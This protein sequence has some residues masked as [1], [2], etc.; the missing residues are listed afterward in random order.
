MKS[1]F[2]KIKI[3]LKFKSKNL[4][5]FTLIEILVAT[6]L[7]VVIAVGGLSILFTAERNYKR[8]ASNSVAMD[9]INLVMDTLSREIK[10]G[11]RYGCINP[12]GSNFKTKTFYNGFSEGNL[13]DNVNNCNAIAFTPQGTTTEKIVYYYDL[14]NLGIN[15]VLYTKPSISDTSFNIVSNSDVALT[16]PDFKV[17]QFWFTIFGAKNNDYNQPNVGIYIDGIVDTVKNTQ[18]VIVATTSIF[19]QSTI[20]Q[21]I[22]DN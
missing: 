17:D 5:A 6:T 4:E 15:Q 18:G 22:L 9:N 20:S 21:R 12:G 8:I 13:T 3:A 14:Q 10:F 1:L 11:N 19:L 16:S 2:N 7:F